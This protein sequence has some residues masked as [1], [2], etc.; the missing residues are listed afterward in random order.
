MDVPELLGR[1]CEAAPELRA[2]CPVEYRGLLED[3]FAAAG[4][5]EP[6]EELLK[7]LNIREFVFED[8][9][10]RNYAPGDDMLGL[11]GS[12]GGH[13]VPG[14]YRCPGAACPRQV[15][16]RPG[17]GQPHCSI[18]DTILEFDAR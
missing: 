3:L 14:V 9:Q 4:R 17:E 13:P 6:V 15:H 2:A 18:R 1:L 5:G 7:T 8:E 10:T 16:P 11:L 12:G